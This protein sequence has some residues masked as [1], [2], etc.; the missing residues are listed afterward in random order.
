[1]PGRELVATTY[2]VDI[3]RDESSAW[4]ATVSGVPGAHTY[5]RSLR[6]VRHRTREALSLWVDDADRAHLEYEIHLPRDARTAVRRASSARKATL[7]AANVS[8][9]ATNDAALILVTDCHLSLRDAA[10]L[11]GLSHQRL[12]QLLADQ[13][14]KPA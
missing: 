11:L 8:S 5:G 13:V 3:E 14:R 9:V 2:H 4:I 6:Q 1:M 12:Q 7:E 10:E